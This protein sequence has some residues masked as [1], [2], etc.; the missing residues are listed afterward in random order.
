MLREFVAWL[1][2]ANEPGADHHPLVYEI[3]GKRLEL[4]GHTALVGVSSV[5]ALAPAP[6]LVARM[7]HKADPLS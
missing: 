5:L 2:R 6:A 3:A 4:D 1:A 7:V